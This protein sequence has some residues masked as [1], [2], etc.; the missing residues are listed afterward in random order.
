[1]AINI[2]IFD[3]ATNRSKTVSC[4]FLADFLA[5]TSGSDPNKLQYFFQLSTAAT[6]TSNI[7]YQTKYVKKLSDLALNGNKRSSVNS[8]V[9]YEDVTTMINDYIY[10]YIYGHTANQFGSGCPLKAPMKF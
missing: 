5:D 7:R 9:E 10:D 8:A 3:K 6:D 4:D 1:M 2:S